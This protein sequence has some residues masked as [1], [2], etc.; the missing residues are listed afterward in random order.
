LRNLANERA[1]GGMRDPASSLARIPNACVA[2]EKI[3]DSLLNIIPLH[4]SVRATVEQILRGLPVAGFSSSAVSAARIAVKSALGAPS[5]LPQPRG[6]QPD[7]FA[8]YCQASG[9]P[10][11]PL[12][13][14]ITNGAPMGAL[15]EITRV[16][17]FPPDVK[18]DKMPPSTLKT[19][20]L[21]GWHNYRSA[22]QEPEIVEGLLNEMITARWSKKYKTLQA[23]QNTLPAGEIKI[24]K[25]GLVS[26]QKPDGSWKHR[27][28]WDLRESG[29]NGAIDQGERTILPRPCDFTRA[30]R[31]LRRAKRTGPGVSLQFL[32]IDI[33]DAFH[34]VPNHPEERH[35][36]AVSFRGEVYVFFVLV[37][38]SSSAPTVWGRF[39]AWLG[40]STMAVCSQLHF[41][42]LMYVDDPVYVAMGLWKEIVDT[43]SLALLWAAAAG[44]PLAWR[45]ADGGQSVTWIGAS[46]TL[47]AGGVEVSIPPSKVTAIRDQLA[48]VLQK[49]LLPLK[50]VRSLAGVLAWVAT[51][52]PHVK[53]FLAGFWAA[54]SRDLG[55]RPV[56]TKHLKISAGW[57]D[58][59]L[60]GQ[61]GGVTVTHRWDPSS[62]QARVR[63][64]TDASPYGMG[65]VLLQDGRPIRYFADEIS[66]LDRTRF[67]AERD[68]PRFITVWESLAILVAL[69][70]WLVKT[71]R[72]TRVEIKSD[73]L[74]SIKALERGTSRAK[75]INAV[76]REIALT[77]AL[78]GAPLPIVRH[79]PGVANVVPDALSRLSAPRPSPLP[80]TLSGVI[81]S[82]PQVR[83]GSFWPTSTNCVK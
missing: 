79:I 8:A 7:I 33:S 66:E 38:G 52:V 45:K 19:L 62:P 17:V 42:M 14:W 31:V 40:R 25:L 48:M 29:V 16:G 18:Q 27:L 71:S 49:P 54:V 23:A 20:S 43:F 2:G 63:I 46:F 82:W 61:Q 56:P 4:E 50:Q 12:S 76:I 83:D 34:Q 58:A 65:G 36:T 78:H 11:T 6:L 70:L 59:F 35:L 26:K 37:F 60:R 9:D 30:S 74:S 75:P 10:D 81:R 80:E 64:C 3:R 44:F 5:G 13:D 15:R 77:E 72:M 39:A 47:A 55:N 51:I 21:A 67:T 32:G 68:D 22:E 73:S 24:N 1:L 41:R 57:L 69:R 53:P 28:V